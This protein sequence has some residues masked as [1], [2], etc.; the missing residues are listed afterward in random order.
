MSKINSIILKG[1]YNENFEEIFYNKNEDINKYKKLSHQHKKP[2]GEGMVNYSNKVYYYKTFIPEQK[3]QSIFYIIVCSKSLSKEKIDEC[4][5]E[6]YEILE[7]NNKFTLKNFPKII[8]EEINEVFLR[9]S[10][11]EKQIDSN[12]NITQLTSDLKTNNQEISTLQFNLDLD[13]NLIPN[14]ENELKQK[15]NEI[16]NKINYKI[17]KINYITKKIKYIYL[18][19]CFILLIFFIFAIRFYLL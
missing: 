6:I 11:N 3:N 15:K 19:S 16:N 8:I 18:I 2:E 17:N 1:V 12:L 14:K 13:N 7:Q 5:E 9:Y 10:Y 4:F